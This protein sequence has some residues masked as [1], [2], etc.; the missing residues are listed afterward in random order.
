MEKVWH[1]FEIWLIADYLVSLWN[2]YIWINYLLEA[3]ANS[4]SSDEQSESDAEDVYKNAT[5]KLG[6]EMSV[7]DLLEK[8]KQQEFKVFLWE[9]AICI[10]LALNYYLK[11]FVCY[12]LNVNILTSYTY[13]LDQFVLLSEISIILQRIKKIQLR[14]FLKQMNAIFC[15]SSQNW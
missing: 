5:G 14:H 8:A 6:E 4:E 1:L 2:S 10:N 13:K 3:D 9:E 12:L 7:T 15:F 11:N